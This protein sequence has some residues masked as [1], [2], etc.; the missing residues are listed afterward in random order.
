MLV[1]GRFDYFPRSVT[2]ALREA[3]IYKDQGIR[4]DKHIMLHYPT[5][6]YYFVNKKAVT[7]AKDIEYG[8]NKAIRDGTFDKLFL[9]YNLDSIKKSG[10]ESRQVFHLQNPFLPKGTPLD[11]DELWY[12]PTMKR[13]KTELTN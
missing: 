11:R 13:I 10:L 4:I 12:A 3:S 8:L 5:A 1:A 2:E 9:E 7:L 6:M